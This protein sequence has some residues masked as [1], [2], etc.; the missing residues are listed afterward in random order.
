M[1]LRVFCSCSKCGRVYE[2]ETD[3]DLR[4][5]Y[6]RPRVCPECQKESK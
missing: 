2:S 4:V 1:K 6:G 5:M 3:Y